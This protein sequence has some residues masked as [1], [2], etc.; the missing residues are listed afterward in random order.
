[1]WRTALC[2]GLLAACSGGEEPR[3]GA[4]QERSATP[5]SVSTLEEDIARGP[6]AV[7]EVEA[8]GEAEIPVEHEP[9]IDLHFLW[10]TPAEADVRLVSEHAFG[11]GAPV[12]ASYRY[13]FVVTH[14]AGAYRITRTGISLE[15]HEGTERLRLG[16]VLAQDVTQ[17]AGDVRIAEDGSRITAVSG[18]DPIEAAARGVLAQAGIEG[19]FADAILQLDRNGWQ[20]LAVVDIDS[21]VHDWRDR[22]LALGAVEPADALPGVEATRVLRA[23]SVPCGDGGAPTCV[24]LVRMEQGVTPHGHLEHV[25]VLLADPQT[26]RPYRF[27][28]EAR[29]VDTQRDVDYSERW[30]TTFVWR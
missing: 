14:E 21:M 22:S 24:E 28:H 18:F 16:N 4:A 30:I 26:L 1:M 11:A 25:Y 17:H 5:T 10:P 3:S 20:A 6:E 9:P 27:E 7:V 2:V 13:R 8:D 19:T 29:T 12:S 23:A 15:S